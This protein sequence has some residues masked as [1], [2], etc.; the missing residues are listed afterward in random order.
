MSRPPPHV[1][2][3]EGV[4][5]S[6][7]EEG[8]RAASSDRAS[9]RR[10]WPGSHGRL[11][12]DG[13][14]SARAH[15]CRSGIARTGRRARTAT[16]RH[17]EG[18]CR[19]LPLPRAKTCL[20]WPPSWRLPLRS[21][22]SRPPPGRVVPGT[23]GSASH[24]RRG[25]RRRRPQRPSR[26]AARHREERVRA[27]P[28]PVPSRRRPSCHWVRHR[29]LRRAN[30]GDP[31]RRLAEVSRG[32]A[33]HHAVLQPSRARTRATGSPGLRG[34][35]RRRSE[36]RRRGSW[37]PGGAVFVL[38]C[39]ESSLHARRRRVAGPSAPF[40]MPTTCASS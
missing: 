2:G 3:K 13:A 35:P 23:P 5:G 8:F 4:S 18:Q 29:Q 27:W 9:G 20:G 40:D 15:C 33:P 25:A 11:L 12:R 14:R 6:S 38:V 36:G 39:C 32:S 10:T 31:S 19:P 21:R 37:K 17:R 34:S 16:Q 7:P 24:C 28:L 22:T 30:E 1:H 26:R